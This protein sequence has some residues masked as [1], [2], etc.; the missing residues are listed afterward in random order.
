TAAGASGAAAAVGAPADSGRQ[1]VHRADPRLVGEVRAFAAR[2]GATP[3]MV[4]LA[5][6]A[7]LLHRVS[8]AGEITVGSPV[9]NR[10][11]AGA[12][13]A[14]GYF[15]NTV[16]LRLA[17]SPADTFGEVVDRAREVCRGAF[18]H[19][20]VDLAD[21][22][23]ELNPDRADGVSSLFSTMFAVRAPAAAAL[24]GRDLR[25]ARRPLH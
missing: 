3:L 6:Y 11:G 24:H 7:A 14:L 20:H 16:C 15:G 17:V 19:A 22:A 4:L 5:G 2:R 13:G 9:V 23:R 10:D 18:A 21:V 8:G 1:L 25:G 12:G